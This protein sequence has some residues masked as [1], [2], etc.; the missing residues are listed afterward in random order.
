MQYF[1]NTSEQETVGD[2]SSAKSNFGRQQ[3]A[4]KILIFGDERERTHALTQ[5]IAMPCVSVAINILE[6]T[7]EK[8]ISLSRRSNSERTGTRN[9]NSAPLHTE[10]KTTN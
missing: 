9:S 5:I 1:Q 6:E 4:Y 2:V 7:E 10:K 8:N 3:K